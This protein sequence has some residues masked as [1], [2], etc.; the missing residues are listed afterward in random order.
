M[1]TST[2]YLNFLQLSESA[3]PALSR[4]NYDEMSI[5]SNPADKVKAA[6]HGDLRSKNIRSV[7]NCFVC[8]DQSQTKANLLPPSQLAQSTISFSMVR[9]P[10][11]RLVSAYQSKY[12]KHLNK[13]LR[14][15]KAYRHYVRPML[16]KQGNVTF[17][18]FIAHVLQQAATRVRSCSVPVLLFVCCY[19]LS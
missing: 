10:W 3:L 5:W 6:N 17:S 18:R 14:N 12:E 1:G 8:R 16:K 2:W 11:E 19:D 9:H 15:D 4:S 7:L 13:S